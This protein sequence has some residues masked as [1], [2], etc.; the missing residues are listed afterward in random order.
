VG[1]MILFKKKKKE[2]GDIGCLLSALCQGGFKKTTIPE[3][4]PSP[5]SGSAGTLILDFPAPRNC[6]KQIFGV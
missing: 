4:V 3:N 5:Y 6:E 2:E 1:L